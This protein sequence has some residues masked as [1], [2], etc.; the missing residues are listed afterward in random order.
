MSNTIAFLIDKDEFKATELR[1]LKR[2]FKKGDLVELLIYERKILEYFFKITQSGE[3]IEVNDM[4]PCDAVDQLSLF[5][6]PSHS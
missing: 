6:L 4:K 5:T 2:L 1:L 3:I